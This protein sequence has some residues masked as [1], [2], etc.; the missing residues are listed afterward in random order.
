[1]FTSALL[2]SFFIVKIYTHC[3]DYGRHINVLCSRDA[4]RNERLKFVVTEFAF[5]IFRALLS[6]LSSGCV[7]TSRMFIRALLLVTVFAC[8]TFPQ[9]SANNLSAVNVKEVPLEEEFAGSS[10][11]LDFTVYLRMDALFKSE[12]FVDPGQEEFIDFLDVSVG[13]DVYYG[14]FFIETNNQANRSNR[15]SSIGYRLVDD[16]DYQID[17]LIGQSYTDGLS[18]KGGNIIRDEPSLELQGIKDR[19]DE[20]NQGLRFTKYNGNQAWWV[21]LAGDPFN[22]SHGGWVVDGYLAHAFQYYNWQFHV[23]VGATFFSAEV[24]DYHAGVSIDESLA[25]RPVYEAGFGTRYSLDLSA[26]YPLSQDWVFVS[27]FTYKHYS[28]SFSNS[29]LYKSNKQTLF[30]LGVMYVW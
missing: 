11:K 9:A 21:D 1:M 27:G 29:P 12:L 19:D 8:L 2:V 24:V 25:E 16:T 5:D 4:K 23:G 15:S 6:F 13:I 3:L 18:E 10:P 7:E 28:K 17:F 14:R 22:I 30:S 20:I 26:Q